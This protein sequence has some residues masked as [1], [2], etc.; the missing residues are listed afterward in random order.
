M[1]VHFNLHTCGWLETR[2]KKKDLH[3]VDSS[4]DYVVEE[5]KQCKSIFKCSV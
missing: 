4:T 5:L 2:V 1:E 3:C